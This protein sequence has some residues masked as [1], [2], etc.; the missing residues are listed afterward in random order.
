MA[1]KDRI[2]K[3]MFRFLAVVSLGLILLS[4]SVVAEA[5]QHV[6]G[7]YRHNGTYVH[8]YYRTSPDN[9]VTNNYSYHGNLSPYTGKIGTN[10]YRHDLTS[11][12]YTGPDIHGKVGHSGAYYMPP[13]TGYS[14]AKPGRAYHDPSTVD[15]CPPPH[16]RITERNGC[17][18]A[19]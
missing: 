14:Y 18:P 6:H 4:T 10:Y 7:Y 12:Y 11:P 13:V 9:T 17:Q 2:G 1:L 5:D 19:H 16:Y 3:P 15:L 8:P